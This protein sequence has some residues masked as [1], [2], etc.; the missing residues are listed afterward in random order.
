MGLRD[1]EG[2]ADNTGHAQ[3]ATI[4]RSTTRNRNATTAAAVQ[5]DHRKY[6]ADCYGSRLVS[7]R[8]ALG[9]ITARSPGQPL[10]TVS[11]IARLAG[12]S[13][14]KEARRTA[15]RTTPWGRQR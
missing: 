6:G 10:R 5:D 8:A 7:S 1:G 3:Q 11:A 2:P 15:S 14:K 9:S 13:A 4:G 12:K